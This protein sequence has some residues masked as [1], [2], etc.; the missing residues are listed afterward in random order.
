[1]PTQLKH[2]EMKP[3]YINNVGTLV[4]IV[5]GAPGS[6]KGTQCEKVASYLRIPHI[7]TG[8][9]LRKQ[10]AQLNSRDANSMIQGEL[11]SDAAVRSLL[12][13]RISAVDCERGFI[14]DGFPR[15]V[16][17]AHLL[18]S[19]LRKAYRDEYCKVVMELIAS[20]A[21]VTRRLSAR[22]I[23][24]LCNSVFRNAN[25][26]SLTVDT[27][28]ADGTTLTKR[29]DDREDVV[30]RRVQAYHDYRRPILS[31]YCNA[32]FLQ[33]EGEGHEDEV[34]S[35]ILEKILAVATFQEK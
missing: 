6:G 5:I 23:C 29:M 27:C 9:M 13:E 10:N 15:T 28:P 18:D 17:Q 34:T 20:K 35:R 4:L 19:Y 25:A 21:T 8:N 31:Y 32:T 14:L 12:I 3:S 1:M 16:N 26:E 11:I 2:C 7:S 22:R 33:V 30:L 24:P